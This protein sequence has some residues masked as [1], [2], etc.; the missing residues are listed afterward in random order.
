MNN[1]LT[2]TQTE[3][4]ESFGRRADSSV[5]TIRFGELQ[6]SLKQDMPTPPFRPVTLINPQTPDMLGLRDQVPARDNR[7]TAHFTYTM[8]THNIPLTGRLEYLQSVMAYKQQ[9]LDANTIAVMGDTEVID[10]LEGHGLVAIAN[11]LKYLYGITE[12]DEEDVKLNSL[13]GFAVFVIKNRNVH[14][15][16]ITITDDGL[17]QAVWKHPQQGTLVMDFHESGDIAFTL[18]YGRWD[19]ETERYK[20]IGELPQDQAILH[21][22]DFIYNS[23]RT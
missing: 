2:S 21:V 19:Q 14:T 13:R 8:D 22:K 12:E 5:E 7:T 1:V 16:Q 17:I 15:P 18:L 3:P 11:R 20:L 6:A 23:I 4:D 10:A 9:F